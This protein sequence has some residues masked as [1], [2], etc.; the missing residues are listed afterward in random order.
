MI[1]NTF[2][3]HV[4]FKNSNDI[5]RHNIVG[6]GYL[7][8]GISVWGKEVDYNV[9]P[10]SASLSDARGRGTDMHSVYMPQAFENPAKGDFR[11]KP[12]AA[13]FSVGFKNIAMDSF[14]VIS[15]GLKALAKKVTY[16][17]IVKPIQAA[18]S[19][20]IDF[21]GAKVK[22]LTTL[23]ERSATGMDGI[24]GIFVIAVT[25]GRPKSFFQVNDV[26]ISLN[27]APTNSLKELQE[28]RMS[29]IGTSAEIV[30]FRN[31][32]VSAERVEFD[33]YK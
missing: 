30:I 29:V 17:N 3:P 20:T 15:P 12:N 6:A 33:K 2:H 10:D 1:N 11:L 21:L 25:P 31:Q 22:K 27:N 24:R 26:I 28:A 5:F 18:E 14:G 9:F 16:S 32:H 7:P 13:A 19:E 8:I 23:G 4:W